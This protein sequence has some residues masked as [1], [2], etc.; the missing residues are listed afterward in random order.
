MAIKVYNYSL[1]ERFVKFVRIPWSWAI[2]IITIIFLLL[3]ILVAFVNGYFDDGIDWGFWRSGLEPVIIVYILVIF[4]FIQKLWERALRSLK[5]LL[6]QPE[7]IN[8][9]NTYKRSREWMSLFLGAVF[10]VALSQPW[11]SIKHWTDLY[12]ALSGIIMFGL[13]GL[14]I[15]S[16][17]TGTIRLARLNRQ[18]LNIDIFDTK[19]LIPVAQWS[20]SVSLA[21]VGGITIS[22]LFQ[23]FENLQSVY[24]IIIYSILICVTVSLFFLSIWSTHDTMAMAKKNELNMVRNNLNNAR[25]E[26]KQCAVWGMYE[27]QVLEIPAWPFNAGVLGRLIASAIVPAIIYIIKIV[28]GLRFG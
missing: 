17:L 26:L 12:T 19:L 20:L 9:I 25:N 22:I 1:L 24:S 11:N 2:S 10:Y 8:G 23:P 13:L 4:P 27:K 14:L 3:L 5:L 7:L 28:F 15:Y 21:F 16:G 6:P 18:H